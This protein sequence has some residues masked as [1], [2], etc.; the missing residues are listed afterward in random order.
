MR[1][2][3][4]HLGTQDLVGQHRAAAALYLERASAYRANLREL[5]A[6]R[7]ERLA[8]HPDLAAYL[9]DPAATARRML[10]AAGRWND[11]AAVAEALRLAKGAA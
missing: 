2:P 11:R 8:R 6:G 7:D 3:F 10:A 9:E 5:R 4:G 1:N